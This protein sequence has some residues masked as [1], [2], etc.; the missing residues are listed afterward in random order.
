VVK[1][2]RIHLKFSECIYLI[3]IQ[4]K[5]TLFVYMKNKF[6]IL[7]TLVFYT[8]VSIANNNLV[9]QKEALINSIFTNNTFLISEKLSI[10]NNKQAIKTHFDQLSQNIYYQ[11]VFL[12]PA[13]W[14]LINVDANQLQAQANRLE[15]QAFQDFKIGD[16]YSAKAK[17]KLAL[18]KSEQAENVIQQIVLLRNLTFI[19]FLGNQYQE[20]A[21]FNSKLYTI[22]AKQ[23]VDYKWLIESILLKAKLALAQGNIKQAEELIY[24]SALPMSNGLANKNLLFE[25]YL[26]LAQI[27]LKSKSFTQSKWFAIQA[28]DLAQKKGLKNK[29]I[30]GL[31]TLAKVKSQTGDYRLAQQNLE[32]ALQMCSK[33]SIYLADVYRTFYQNFNKMGNLSLAKQYQAK[34]N[35]CK[36]NSF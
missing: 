25:S 7:F 36:K 19:S 31:I 12:I 27:Y 35:F 17:F 26:I 9:S 15:L 3:K 18:I 13:I 4:N 6:L 28:L 24:K 32:S 11:Q 2:L 23:K 21:F 8:S 30:I 29:Q 33:N 34:F 22:L 20:T 14:K 16:Y 10:I 5:C 1:I